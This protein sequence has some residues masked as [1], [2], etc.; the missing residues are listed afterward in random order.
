MQLITDRN[1]API[2]IPKVGTAVR[3][4][5]TDQCRAAEQ[6][7]V[8]QPIEGWRGT[9]RQGGTFNGGFRMTVHFS[10]RSRG[11]SLWQQISQ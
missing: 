3:K 4:G 6:G 1:H 11:E 8:K 10:K 7:E 2:V 9:D 5:Q